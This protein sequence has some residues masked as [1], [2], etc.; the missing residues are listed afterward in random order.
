VRTVQCSTVKTDHTT[1]SPSVAK[2]NH[3]T[4]NRISG[5]GVDLNWHCIPTIN[6]IELTN[7][8]LES[9]DDELSSD[10]KN[11]QY[12]LRNKEVVA[13]R[14][15]NRHLK[16][17]ETLNFKSPELFCPSLLYIKRPSVL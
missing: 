15:K 14:V 9:G 2:S 6:Q 16:I 1:V 4:V 12:S 13:K 11:K 8:S 7:T 3:L 5:I 17:F 10:I